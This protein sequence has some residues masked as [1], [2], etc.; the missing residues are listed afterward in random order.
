MDIFTS[1]A[2][3]MGQGGASSSSGV[4]PVFRFLVIGAIFGLAPAFLARSKGR[5]FFLW[6]ILGIISWAIAAIVLI[7]LPKNQKGI[8]ERML[9][10]GFRKCP[11][12]SELIKEEALLCKHCNTDLLKFVSQAKEAKT[13]AQEAS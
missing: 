2:M 4:E 12:C 7:F 10:K 9:K 11:A 3:A 13:S 1:I 5:S 8:D 6:Y